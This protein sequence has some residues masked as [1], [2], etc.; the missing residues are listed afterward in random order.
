[1]N[2][3]DCTASRETFSWALLQLLLQLIA[4]YLQIIIDCGGKLSNKRPWWSKAFDGIISRLNSL[5]NY[6]RNVKTQE[7]PRM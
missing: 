3:I 4:A 7:S 6:I 5:A 2:C 1:M